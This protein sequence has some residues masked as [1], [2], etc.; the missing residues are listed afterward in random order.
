M[1]EGELLRIEHAF[2]RYDG[3]IALDDAWLSVMPGEVLALMGENG[4]GKSTLSKILAGA[5]LPDSAEIT[6][7]GQPVQITSPIMAQRLGIGMVFQ[8][9]DLFPH[10]SVAENIVIGN[11]HAE[12]GS[13]VNR[14]K[15]AAFCR[16]YLDQVGLSVDPYQPVADLSI[17]QM[18]LVAIARAL[19]FG[20]RLILMD[21]PTS[22]LSEDAV[23]MLFRLIHQLRASGV[24]IVYVSHKMKEI[25]EIADRITVMGDGK[26]I[27]S[28]L[29]SETDVDEI[30]QMMVGRTLSSDSHASARTPGELL[31]RVQGLTT[32]HIYGVSFDLGRGEILGVAGLVGAGRS[33]IGAALFGLDK[34]VSGSILLKGRKI[35]PR[36]PKEAIRAGLGLL[37]EDRKLQGLMMQMSVLE[38]STMA[39]LPQFQYFGFLQPRQEAQ[40]SNSIGQRLALRAASDKMSVRGLSGGN[41]QKVLLAK[42]LLADPEVLFLDDPTRGIDIGAKRDIY[43]IIHHLADGG[44]GIIFVSSEVP[45]LLGRCHRILV[46]RE[47]RIA[48]IL[49]GHEATQE[50]IMQLAT[51]GGTAV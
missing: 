29:A 27:G 16:P 41:Q 10:L 13:W 37:P 4:A 48:G 9:L 11:L 45:E 5:V 35:T 43:Q 8:E 26:T 51:V 23:Q 36:N 3:A 6:L 20:A 39:T 31:L 1:P 40:A 12:S 19:S 38:N 50:T 34:L 2:K 15:L 49:P 33:E 32:S 24:S 14:R 28:K 44:K 46:M 25:F 17:G 42:W 7:H 18:Q 30:I 47:G 22:A 21:E